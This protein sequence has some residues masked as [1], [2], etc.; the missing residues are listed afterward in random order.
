MKITDYTYFP[1]PVLYEDHDI[2]DYKA[3]SI[4]SN[5][6]VQFGDR[7]EVKINY[8]IKVKQDYL[9]SLLDK[10]ELKCGLLI[11]C[12]DTFYKRL[13]EINVNI[14]DDILF[15]EGD[16]WGRVTFTPIL[17]ANTDINNLS[18]SDFHDDYND[19][20][21]NIEKGSILGVGDEHHDNI[22]EKYDIDSLIECRINNKLEEGQLEYE[23]FETGYIIIEVNKND[24]RELE[25]IKKDRKIGEVYLTHSMAVPAIMYALSHVQSDQGDFGENNRHPLWYTQFDEI[26]REKNIDINSEEF[27]IFIHTQELLKSGKN[28]V[29]N[30][31]KLMDYS[32]EDD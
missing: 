1:H 12:K 19:V 18:T 24:F 20:L 4:I 17:F 28:R 25:R 29:Y 26:L 7:D 5:V 10:E 14:E 11:E 23:I 2:N 8:E 27:D 32:L 30:N 3:G 13:H 16:L 6:S 21:I 22:N 31:F 9:L 15:D